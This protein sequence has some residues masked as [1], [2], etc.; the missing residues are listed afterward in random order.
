MPEP[1]CINCARRA[2]WYCLLGNTSLSALQLLVGFIGGSTALIAEGIHTFTD[3]I[4]TVV[5]IVSR[6]VSAKPAD[7]EH[8]YGHGKVEFIGSAFAYIALLFLSAAIFSGGLI[9]ILTHHYRR[10]EVITILASCVAVLIN[11]FMYKLGMCSGIRVNS[12]VLVANA[13]ENRADAMSSAAVIVGIS[14]SIF[15]HPVCDP[16]AAMV[17]GVHIFINCMIR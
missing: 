9:M 3:V 14:A 6:G 13:F 8:T 15:I 2:P 5:V 4:G 16:I 7:Q 17:V 1:R 11:G 12:P 10:P